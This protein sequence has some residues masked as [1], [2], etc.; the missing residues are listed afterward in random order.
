MRQVLDQV[1]EVNAFLCGKIENYLLSI[2]GILALYE[3][4]VH[5]AFF[6]FVDTHAASTT[7]IVFDLCRCRLIMMGRFAHDGI[8]VLD[9]GGLVALFWWQ[10]ALPVLKSPI[11][12][13]DT[14]VA[15]DQ[16]KIVADKIEYTKRLPHPHFH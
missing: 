16:R 14:V 6:D 1:T 11:R 3:F 2:K 5:V 15:T 12:L 8:R 10:Y 4:H 13:D 7:F 9:L